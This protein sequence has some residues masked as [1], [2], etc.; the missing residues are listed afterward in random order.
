MTQK[1]NQLFKWISPEREGGFQARYVR[2]TAL[3]RRRK[4]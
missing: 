4:R 1:Y 2:L 3:Y